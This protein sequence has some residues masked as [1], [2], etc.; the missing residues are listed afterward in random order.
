MGVWGLFVAYLFLFGQSLF[1]L[2]QKYIFLLT[3]LYDFSTV[4][5]NSKTH[6]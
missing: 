2:I 3:V 1:S 5:T 6:G 4:S